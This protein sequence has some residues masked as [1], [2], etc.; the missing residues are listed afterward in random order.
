MAKKERS[1]AQQAATKR[2]LAGARRARMA[3]GGTT[4]KERHAKKGAAK[5]HAKKGAKKHATT[6][7][8]TSLAALAKTVH[9]HSQ[10]WIK[11][12]KTN[13]KQAQINTIFRAGIEG[14]YNMPQLAGPSGHVRQLGRGR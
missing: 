7:G 3:K 9:S 13:H 6:H 11:Q 12:E 8:G 10:K 14:I 2:M 5:R 1:P 4:T